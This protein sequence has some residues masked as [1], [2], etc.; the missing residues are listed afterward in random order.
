LLSASLVIEILKYI[1]NNTTIVIRFRSSAVSTDEVIVR[2]V[3]MIMN[4]GYPENLIDDLLNL[5]NGKPN[6]S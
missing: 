2:C 6:K 3:K 5:T 4:Y 1:T